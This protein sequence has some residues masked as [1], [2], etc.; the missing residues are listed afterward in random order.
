[1]ANGQHR[2]IEAVVFDAMYTII[3]PTGTR[4]EL[5]A[6][7]LHAEAGITAE[8]AVLNDLILELRGAKPR[9]RSVRME[10]YWPRINAQL[11]HRLA[12]GKFDERTAL[13]IGRAMHVRTLTDTALYTVRPA[14]RDLLTWLRGRVTIAI[15]SNQT[16]QALR[17]H[18]RAAGIESL[19]TSRL[20]TSGRVGSPKPSRYFWHAVRRGVRASSYGALAYVGNSV[21]NDIELARE[22]Q[23]PVAL[24]DPSRVIPG[25]AVAGVSVM[26]DEM[27]LRIW[28]EH[29]LHRHEVAEDDHT[30]DCAAMDAPARAS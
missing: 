17:G 24:F 20:Y 10:Q 21:E 8:P 5:N 13:R 15:A 2:R 28:L 27:E 3:Q 12:Q 16:S 11:L 6:R 7:V 23:S 9:E 29:L 18:L 1:M 30:H 25:L 22:R 14:M 4:A 19:F 26:H